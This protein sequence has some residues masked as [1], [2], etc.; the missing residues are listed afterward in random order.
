MPYAEQVS[1]T[2][3]QSFISS[4]R[5]IFS[6]NTPNIIQGWV[7]EEAEPFSFANIFGG[8]KKKANEPKEESDEQKAEEPKKGFWPF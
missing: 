3:L 4:C 6:F 5:V 1:Q 2:Q 8:G 7:D